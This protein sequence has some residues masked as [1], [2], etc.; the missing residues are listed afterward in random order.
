[1]KLNRLLRLETLV[2]PA[3][4]LMETLCIYPW[5]VWVGSLTFLHWEKAPLSLL[6]SL[7]I[8]GTTAYVAN[9]TLAK[10]WPLNK[11]RL[12]TLGTALVLVLLLTRLEHGG[13]YALWDVGW[14]RFARENLSRLLGALGFGFYLLWRGIVSGRERLEVS[15]L[16]HNFA[17]G[18]GGLI[19]LTI[20]WAATSRLVTKPLTF[21]TLGPYVLGYFFVALM[22]LGLSNLKTL[23]KRVSGTGNISDLLTRRWVLLLLSIVLVIVLVGTL[24]ASTLSVNVMTLILPALSVLRDWLAAAFLYVVLYPIGYLVAGLFYVVRF[25]L[26]FLRGNQPWENPE[27]PDFGDL[28]EIIRG[29]PNHLPPELMLAL[30][31]TLLALVV[32]VIIFFLAKALFRYWE[33]AGQKGIEEIH[34]SLW[35]WKTFRADVRSFFRNLLAKLRKTTVRSSRP[36][37]PAAV[38]L[39]DANQPLDIR[40]LY[41]GLLWEGK[42]A[43][44][45]KKSADTPYEYQGTLGKVVPGER[46]SLAAL[47]EAYVRVRYGHTVIGGE[48]AVGLVRQWLRLRSAFRSLNR[49]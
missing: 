23:R 32:G 39:E 24:I 42:Q 47:T 20:I 18:V 7:V 26:Q 21:T 27:A 37:P 25:L 3:V 46:A 34:E 16:Y 36:V 14:A 30:K 40:E 12:A 29:E 2:A 45:A 38:T 17:L 1:L 31:W 48:H 41:R 5:V 11:A 4:V 35:S 22:A 19:L 9:T 13:G 8:L 10:K 43:G 28:P 6:S 33:G 15:Y 44:L 49:A